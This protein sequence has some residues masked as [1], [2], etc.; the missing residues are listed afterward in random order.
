M[1]KVIYLVKPPE[2]EPTKPVQFTHD[3]VLA[4]MLALECFGSQDGYEGLDARIYPQLQRLHSEFLE[5]LE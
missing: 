3:D 4:L 1:S 2:P 5:D